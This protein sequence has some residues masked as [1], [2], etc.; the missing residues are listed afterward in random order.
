VVLLEIAEYG[1]RDR[2]SMCQTQWNLSVRNQFG[3]WLKSAR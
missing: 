2:A 3:A 1:T